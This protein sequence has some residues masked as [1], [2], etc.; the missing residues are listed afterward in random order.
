MKGLRRKP[1]QRAPS[2]DILVE[3][4][5]WKAQRGVAAL[6]R[7]AVTAAAAAVP[8]KRGELAIVLVDDS[9]MR[10]LNRTWRRKNAPTNVLSFPALQAG[11]TSGA[12]RLM[13]DIVIAYET[14]LREARA[15]R[16]PLQ[17]HLAHLV[18][19]GYLHL[20]GYDHEAEAE[21]EVMEQL[22]IAALARLK[23]PNPYLARGAGG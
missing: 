17:H 8:T 3:S 11:E 12:D 13:G 15:E 6:L 23:V 1:S 19:H 7:R 18:V 4:P 9:A 14:T 20:A 5:R 22:E 16:K 21:A 2:I 10:E